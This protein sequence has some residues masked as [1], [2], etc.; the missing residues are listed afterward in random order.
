MKPLQLS[1]YEQDFLLGRWD[2]V[3]GGAYNQVFE[4]CYE[5]GLCDSRG[6][7]TEHGKKVLDNQP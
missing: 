3:G 7:I 6:K 4:F 2:G 1:E 5:N